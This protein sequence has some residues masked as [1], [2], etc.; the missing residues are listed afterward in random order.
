M[1]PP[2]GFLL[3]Y[4]AIWGG[5]LGA[6]ALTPSIPAAAVAATR[7]A[8]AWTL[9]VLGYAPVVA[10]NAIRAAGT[11]FQIDPECTPTLPLLTLAAAILAHPGA[12]RGRALG[13]AGAAGAAP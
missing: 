11:G 9:R 2:R 1:T 13:V 10:G 8:T 12:W 4:L 7:D 6:Y 5:L 3:R